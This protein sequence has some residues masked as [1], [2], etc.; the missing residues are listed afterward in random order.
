MRVAEE[1]AVFLA[2]KRAFKTVSKSDTVW[3]DALVTLLVEPSCFEGCPCMTD[4]KTV[5]MVETALA[6]PLTELSVGVALKQNGRV[7]PLCAVG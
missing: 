7:G 6:G 1:L 3:A 2:F 5:L 4:F